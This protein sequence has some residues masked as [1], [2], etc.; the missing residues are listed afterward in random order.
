MNANAATICMTTYELKPAATGRTTND[1][2]R[3]N[4]VYTGGS[5]GQ[6]GGASAE[7]TT[8]GQAR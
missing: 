6:C 7:T 3:S 4:G 8:R 2:A 5:A 1:R